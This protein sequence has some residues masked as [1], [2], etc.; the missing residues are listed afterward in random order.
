[1]LCFYLIALEKFFHKTDELLMQMGLNRDG[2]CYLMKR[3]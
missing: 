3:R 1:M 2:T